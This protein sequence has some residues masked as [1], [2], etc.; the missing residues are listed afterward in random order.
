[1]KKYFKVID[2]FIGLLS[3]FVISFFW[4]VVTYSSNYYQHYTFF[5]AGSRG[6]QSL[7]GFMMISIICTAG[8]TLFLWIPGL[9]LIGFIIRKIFEL[10]TGIKP[11]PTDPVAEVV[12]QHSVFRPKEQALTVEEAEQVAKQDVGSPAN[13]TYLDSH[14]LAAVLGY[15]S[16]AKATGVMSNEVIRTNLKG[17]GW[18]D[19]IID[20][21]FRHLASL[22][23]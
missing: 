20:N 17:G 6:M 12:A 13:N 22:G 3:A 14:N 23:L 16:S 1:M 15:I 18:S 4:G 11:K 7:V 10:F 21:G 19:E 5:D 8:I 2:F 9:S